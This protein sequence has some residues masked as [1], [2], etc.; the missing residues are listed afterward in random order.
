MRMAIGV[1][2][3]VAALLVAER[4]DAFCGFY[5]GGAD[6]KLFNNATQVVLMRD[7][8]RTVL[9]MQNDYE[10]P[11]ERFAMVVPVPVVL[12]KE[13]VKT[14]PAAIFS[15]VDK[16]GAPR[17]VE[18]WEQDPCGGGYG[19]GFGGGGRAAAAAPMASKAA[20]ADER[21]GVR[22]EAR[23]DVGEYDI[24]I[25]SAKDSGGLET[26][27]KQEK[28]ALPGG[29]EP[30]FRP[31][32]QAGS[33]FFVAKVDPARV[34]MEKGHAALSPLRF[35]YDSPDFSLPVRLGLI[36]SR[37]TQDL[38]VNIIAEDRYEPANYPSITIPTNLDLAEGSRDY[39]GNFYTTLFDRTLEKNPKAIVTEYSW[40]ASTCDPCPGPALGPQDFVTLGADVL[41]RG[42]N[43]PEPPK[44]GPPVPRVTSEAP[45]G[46][47][48]AST[49]SLVPARFKSRV[50]Q[51]WAAAADKVK[52]G[53][54]E[55][56]VAWD[57]EGK[58][59]SAK[60][61]KNETGSAELADCV[62]KPFETAQMPTEA[63]SLALPYLMEMHQPTPF[64]MSY[65]SWTITRLHARY[66]KDALGQDIVFRKAKPI[67]GGRE[68]RDSNGELEHGATTTEGQNNFQGRYA[69]RHRWV[70][71]M[72]CKEPRRNQWGG[73]WPELWQ[74]H[75]YGGAFGQGPTA[76]EKVA[77][78]PRGGP[79]LPAFVRSDVPELGVKAGKGR[80]PLDKLPALAGS[81][82]TP[83]L[84]PDGAA[85]GH[86]TANPGCSK[87]SA[88]GAGLGGGSMG[89]FLLGVAGLLIRR[90]ARST[91]R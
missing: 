11:P 10:G 15:T 63:G 36:N 58:V 20:F 91:A 57:D 54:V 9:S 14:L 80:L 82:A 28:Y 83:G 71:P 30:Y 53:R 17:L 4:A 46:K 88:G 35:H 52:P 38:V 13:N 44:P 5:V 31:Y 18:Y 45:V 47:A 72:E 32:V 76:A 41:P 66:T 51:C 68:V 89:G 86:P 8:T 33:K 84:P 87:C 16:L 65:R 23:F 81:G 62:R 74:T 78:A 25:L 12:Q 60:I 48:S 77:F 24:V 64:G 55:V 61:T 49:M 69:I 2:T 79:E 19:M 75:G 56:T 37:G 29:A 3:V 27:L 21:L 34:K 22:V 26:W 6:T 90:R 43:D 42:K 39:F 59:T 40:A 73:P 67:T 1:V 85:P 50:D 70:G 7:G